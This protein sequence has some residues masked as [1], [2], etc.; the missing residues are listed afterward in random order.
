MIS[1][2]FHLPTSSHLSAPSPQPYPTGGDGVESQGVADTDVAAEYSRL[3]DFEVP[4]II[5]NIPTYELPPRP[6]WERVGERG[7]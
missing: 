2:P 1:C 6:L 5:T 7:C 4:K 3:L